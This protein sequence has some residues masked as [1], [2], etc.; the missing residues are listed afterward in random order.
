MNK[1]NLCTKLLATAAIF[2]AIMLL[3]LFRIPCVILTLT[4]IE[5]FG[6]GLTRA[7]ISAL[8]FDF[9]AAFR[10]HS[11]FWSIPILYLYF[12]FDGRLFSLKPNLKFLDA[13]A[14]VLIA[15]GFLLNWLK[16]F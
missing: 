12:L 16:I 10:Y 1:I 7:V 9:T 15:I 8:K 2:A 11:M 3:W 5:C 6:C 4:G 14:L 13:A